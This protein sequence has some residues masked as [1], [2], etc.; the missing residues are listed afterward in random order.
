MTTINV[1]PDP[2]RVPYSRLARNQRY[3]T[4]LVKYIATRGNTYGD[5]VPN[6]NFDAT[7]CRKHM[8]IGICGLLRDLKISYEGFSGDFIERFFRK[9]I[10]KPSILELLSFR[11]NMRINTLRIQIVIVT[12]TQFWLM[13]L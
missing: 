4:L 3:P 12:V 10:F 6:Y 1:F 9:S 11:S 7:L 2:S 8:K 5:C 13:K